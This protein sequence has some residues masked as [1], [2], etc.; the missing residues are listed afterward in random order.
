MRPA[1]TART[2]E[3]LR[4]SDVARSVGVSPSILRTW[5]NLGLVAP[6]RTRS[7][8]RL[9]TQADVRILK[10]AQYLR[11]VRGLNAP[12]IVH[13][14]KREGVLPASGARPKADPIGPAPAAHAFAQRLFP[15]QGGARD[16][17]I[18]GIS[19]RTGTRADDG[20]RGYFAAY[21]ALLSHE[22]SRAL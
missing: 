14:L 15:F 1:K 20:F 18:R 6:Q 22:Y 10:R 8:Y 16:G 4:I 2:Q 7:Q 12:A 19:Q 9:Y 21:R 11:R 5:E 3:F 13:L 17:R